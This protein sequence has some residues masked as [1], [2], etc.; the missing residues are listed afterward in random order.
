MD[1][2]ILYFYLTS[3]GGGRL[4]LIV[5]RARRFPQQYVIANIFLNVEQRKLVLAELG[6][7]SKNTLNK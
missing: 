3:H 4:D 7:F 2:I 5:S 1:F 6:L